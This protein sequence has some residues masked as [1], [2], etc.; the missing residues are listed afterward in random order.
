MYRRT[1]KDLDTGFDIGHYSVT[2]VCY[3]EIKEPLSCVC[4]KVTSIMIAI[5]DRFAN[6]VQQIAH[7]E[8]INLKI[9][10]YFR[11]SKLQWEMA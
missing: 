7:T 9:F 4:L 8:G 1:D 6:R 2:H 10:Y 5:S 11:F 3:C